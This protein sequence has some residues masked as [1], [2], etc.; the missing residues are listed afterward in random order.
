MDPD[1]SRV[2]GKNLLF[3]VSASATNLASRTKVEAP[4]AKQAIFVFI[5]IVGAAVVGFAVKAYFGG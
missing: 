3:P 4:M 2:S 1:L 5:V